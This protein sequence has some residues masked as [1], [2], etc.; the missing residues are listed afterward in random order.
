MSG[1]PLS[2]EELFRG[3]YLGGGVKFWGRIVLGEISWGARGNYSGAI[4]WGGFHGGQLSG[5]QLFIQFSLYR[6]R[7]ESYIFAKQK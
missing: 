1:E 5:G 3:N 4:V 6:V 2:R 7:M